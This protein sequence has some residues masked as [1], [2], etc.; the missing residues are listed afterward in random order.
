VSG[1]DQRTEEGKKSPFS[2]YV[3]EDLRAQQKGRQSNIYFFDCMEDAIAKY[4]SLP[5]GFTSA[6]GF[7]SNERSNDKDLIQRR[8]GENVFIQDFLLSD[9]NRMDPRIHEM[10]L[11]ACDRLHVMWE[12]DF[13]LGSSIL[14]P[15][16]YGT[17]PEHGRANYDPYFSDKRLDFYAYD[18]LVGKYL[19]M[20]GGALRAMEEVFLLEP[21]QGNG[22]GHLN[23]EALLACAGASKD[24]YVLED[25][26]KVN[27]FY[28]NYV[29][30]HGRFGGADVN[31]C[32]MRA[33]LAREKYLEP[34]QDGDFT[35]W[36][37]KPESIQALAKDLDEFVWDLDTYHYRDVSVTLPDGG[38]DREANILQ[39]S[40]DL[41]KGNVSGYRAYLEEI[42]DGEFDAPWRQMAQQLLFQLN[43][44][45]PEKCRMLDRMI[46]QAQNTSK[47][48]ND[49]TGQKPSPNLGRE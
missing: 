22:S 4:E 20:K 10:A 44:A 48:L 47:L 37:L 29:D 30:D 24:G 45:C 43:A 27:S 21:C 42:L 11:E 35:S 2:F 33:L 8:C 14:I 19:P 38:L 3:F 5:K 17:S 25:R 28:I 16:E 23:A 13:M 32:T 40:E 36:T 39:V 15:R 18:N 12:A 7:S 41:R 1:Y 26:P 31:P 34:V 6:L 9:L 49:D 46:T